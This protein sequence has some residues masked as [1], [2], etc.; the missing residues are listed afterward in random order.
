[1]IDYLRIGGELLLHR[2]PQLVH[3]PVVLAVERVQVTDGMLNCRGRTSN[4]LDTSV[5]AWL[6][7]FQFASVALEADIIDLIGARGGYCDRKGFGLLFL[8]EL[9]V[10]WLDET[11]ERVTERKR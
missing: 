4:A 3:K 10:F 8:F 7:F 2:G 11:R 9:F 6:K 1:M 5:P